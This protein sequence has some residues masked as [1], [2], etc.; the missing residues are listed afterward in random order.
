MSTNSL[1]DLPEVLREVKARPLFVLTLRVRKPLVVGATPEAFRHIGVIDGGSFSGERLSGEVLDSGS[2]WQTLRPDHTTTIDVRL[3]LKT[4]DGALIGMRYPGM[5]HGSAEVM[6]RI[7]K[8]EIPPPS[9]YYLRIAPSF[10]TSAAQYDWLNRI[11]AIG[12]G[13]RRPDDVL[14]S[15]FEIL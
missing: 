6:A 13:H 14:Y 5:R 8:G 3:V 1:Q 7:S 9:D 15:I 2:D 10:V 4:N 11:V 12:I